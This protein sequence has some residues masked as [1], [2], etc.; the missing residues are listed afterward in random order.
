MKKTKISIIGCGNI[1]LSIL[2]GII[3]SG[4]VEKSDLIV[5]RRNTDELDQLKNTGIRITSD[6]AEA[7]QGR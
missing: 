7:V 5:T 2:Q 1:G 6:N 3:K 4:S